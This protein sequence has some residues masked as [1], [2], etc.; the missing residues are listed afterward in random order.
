MGA[1]NHGPFKIFFTMHVPHILEQ[2]FFS[3]DYRSFKTC[4]KVSKLWNQLLT[5]ESYKRKGKCIFYEEITEEVWNAVWEGNA[6][7]VR[8]LLSS[9]MVY[10]NLEKSTFSGFSTLLCSAVEKGDKD[11]AKLLLDSGAD[12]NKANNA[13]GSPLHWAAFGGQA[14]IVKLLLKR[15]ADFDKANDNGSTPLYWA[16][17]FGHTN[18]VKL[19]LQAGADPMKTFNGRTPLY[20]ATSS[21]HALDSLPEIV[22]ILSNVG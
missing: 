9:G 21:I 2:I 22:D 14:D 5:S 16:A 8:K 19:L 6:E 15:G 3:L 13:R 1:G 11:V 10:V 7:E 4:M 17:Y 18:V 20:A 12:P